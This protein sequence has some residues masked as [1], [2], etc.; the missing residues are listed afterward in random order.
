MDLA[1]C[2]GLGDRELVA[3][4]GAG[5]KKTAMGHLTARGE[6]RDLAVGYTTTTHT[7]PPAN[8]PLVLTGERSPL[9]A[10]EGATS[11]VA[12]AAERVA[13]PDRA[14]EK[15]RGF[16]P[17]VIDE[18]CGSGRFDWLLVKADG[19]RR[20]EFKAPGPEEPVVPGATTHVVPVASVQA[21]GE[22]LDAPAVHRPERV[23]AVAGVDVGDSV[24]PATVGQVLGSDEG[25][26]KRVPGGAAVTPVVNKADT[27]ELR[28]QAR[29]ALS[30]ALA[31]SDRLTRGLVT[32]FEAGYCEVVE[33]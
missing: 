25:G 4:V 32:S 29:E 6:A 31:Q 14:T 12:F 27:A 17:G 13:D 21:V 24:T 30:V 3:F 28:E 15:V 5:G 22:P 19:A 9:D 2:L 8:L 10:L 20:R 1:D 7:P 26:L 33:L 16:D 18:V 11:P 23:A